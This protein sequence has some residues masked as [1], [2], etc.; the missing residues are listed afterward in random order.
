MKSEDGAPNLYH[1][2]NVRFIEFI[3]SLKFL[4]FFFKYFSQ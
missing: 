3:I 2:A 1:T 4:L